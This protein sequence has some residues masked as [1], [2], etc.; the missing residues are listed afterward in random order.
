MIYLSL[1]LLSFAQ[2][3]PKYEMISY[4]VGFLVKGPKWTAESSE[5]TKRIQE[6]HMGHIR[7]MADSGKLV[8]AGPFMDNGELRGML[9]FKDLSLEEA[10]KVADEDPAVKAGRLVV[11]LHP[12]FAGKGLNVPPPGK[13]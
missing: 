1:S 13:Q 7:K 9:V 5:E 6:G 4:V 8:V 11:K 12:W 10:R 3:P 2:P